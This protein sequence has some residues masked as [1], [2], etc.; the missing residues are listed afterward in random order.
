MLN[1]FVL[2]LTS[3][4]HIPLFYNLHFTLSV[5]KNFFQLFVSVS[6]QDSR[7]FACAF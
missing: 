4:L 2:N 3:K 1:N 7:G 5:E 6:F